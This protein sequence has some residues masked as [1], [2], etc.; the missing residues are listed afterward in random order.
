MHYSTESWIR[1]YVS[2][3]PS[4]QLSEMKAPI[5]FFFSLVISCSNCTRGFA[6]LRTSICWNCVSHTY[7]SLCSTLFHGVPPH[8]L[9]TFHED[10]ATGKKEGN[11]SRE[12]N[13]KG[14]VFQAGNGEHSSCVCSLWE[15][16]TTFRGKVQC[17]LFLPRIKKCLLC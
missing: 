4:A 14:K 10:G 2:N 9:R 6:R 8:Y 5:S 3:L 13:A 12:G 16:G 11:G 7:S 15:L 1:F 17:F